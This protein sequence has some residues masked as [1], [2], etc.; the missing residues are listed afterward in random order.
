MKI[1]D[2]N[3]N[4]NLVKRIGFNPYY[5]RVES[6]LSDRIIINNEKFI[7][8]AS[9]NYLGLANDERIKEASINA[10]KKYGVSFC[11]TPIACGYNDLYE[12]V[13]K[14][15][16][17]FTGCED[18][19]LLPSCYQANNG[20]FAA[21]SEKNDIFIFDRMCHSSLIQ[22]IMLANCRMRY[23]LHNNTE[24]LES[25]LKKSGDYNNR[26]VVIESVF[27]TEGA[28]APV[29]IMHDLC[30]KY[31]AY[32]IID[33]SH[34]IGVL[35]EK[36]HGV[37]EHFKI[38]D[39]NGI[40]LA[41]LGKALANAG[42]VIAGKK[43]MIEYLK[44]YVPHLIYS[45]AIVPAVL[46]G[47]EKV[48][49]IVDLEFSVLSGRLWKNKNTIQNALKNAGFDI[50]DSKAPI[51]SIESGSTE[52]TFLMTK[53][54]YNNRLF[55]TPF[56]EPSTP[57]NRSKIRMIAGAN[58]TEETLNDTVEIISSIGKNL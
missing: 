21:L 18:S 44:Y 42:G 56:V 30:K 35:G 55:V 1:N 16:S 6:D 25:I 8:L 54:F 22:G 32:L 29:D 27:S 4:L 11:G 31:D 43:D 33:D 53:K 2:Y 20:V 39:F 24:D 48:L 15:L 45:T 5:N 14:K 12:K 41:S 57:K 19:I 7:D 38:N 50:V 9:N 23:F 51:N 37:I 3:N 40:Y 34:G 17:E 13:N 10:V 36:G 52:N 47:I 28:I 46:G 58:F 26:Y 49:E